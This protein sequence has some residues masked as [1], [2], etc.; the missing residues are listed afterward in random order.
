MLLRM[1]LKHSDIYDI[2]QPKCSNVNTFEWCTGEPRNAY[3]YVPISHYLFCVLENGMASEC[4]VM[5]KSFCNEQFGFL[6]RLWQETKE[7]TVL[8]TWK[9]GNKYAC[10]V[11]YSTYSIRLL[12][13]ARPPHRNYDSWHLSKGKTKSTMEISTVTQ[14]YKPYVTHL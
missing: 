4:Y 3:V 5:L 10:K 2:S 1:S 13:P 7:K 11:G 12:S 6:P 8:I 14:S 9:V